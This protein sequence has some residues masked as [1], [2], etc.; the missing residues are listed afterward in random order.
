MRI[1]VLTLGFALAA[2][3]AEI[4]KGSHVLLRLV[5][6]I[7]TRTARKGDYI[8]FRTASPIVAGNTILVPA[9]SYVQGVVTRSVRSGRVKGW[10]EL[11]IQIENLTL[12]SGGMVT[13]L[14]WNLRVEPGG[15]GVFIGLLGSILG[16]LAGHA[17][18]LALR[19]GRAI[20]Q[21]GVTFE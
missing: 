10:A 12:P 20:P 13:N 5:N 18:F 19:N 9:D 2:S 3:A 14:F 21:P 7:T 4:P 11:A 6:T 16:L 1:A 17:V 15:S 8:Y